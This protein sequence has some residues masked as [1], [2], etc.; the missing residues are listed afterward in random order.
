[1]AAVPTES[2]EDK[3]VYKKANEGS[4]IV[5]DV[6]HEVFRSVIIENVHPQ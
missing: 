6:D 4:G 5:Q 2:C 1:M 3:N